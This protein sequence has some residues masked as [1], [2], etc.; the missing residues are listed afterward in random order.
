[1]D[2]FLS[3]AYKR[4]P[5]RNIWQSSEE[6]STEK[7]AVSQRVIDKKET[8]LED[9]WTTGKMKNNQFRRAPGKKKTD[10]KVNL[11]LV[12]CFWLRKKFQNGTSGQA[13]KEKH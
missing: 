5:K 7:A 6:K 10:K 2:V 3:L 4:F 13:L 8:G 1:M 9:K 11:Y 12:S